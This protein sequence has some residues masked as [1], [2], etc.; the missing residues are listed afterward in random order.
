M[1]RILRTV[2]L[3]PSSIIIRLNSTYKI[4]IRNLP[5]IEDDEDDDVDSSK[6]RM[7]PKDYIF[8]DSKSSRFKEKNKRKQNQWLKELEQRHIVPK[9]PLSSFIKENKTT[10]EKLIR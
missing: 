2:R 6:K 3:L 4:P 9:T 10:S 5:N 8:A 7:S 1:Y